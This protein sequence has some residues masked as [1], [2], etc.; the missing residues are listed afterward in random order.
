M[1][2]HC[3]FR[4]FVDVANHNLQAL[5]QV[6]S[7][8]L[9]Q[10]FLIAHERRH[11]VTAVDCKSEDTSPA[12]A[13]GAEQKEPHGYTSSYT[14]SSA[15]ADEANQGAEHAMHRVSCGF[16][17][18]ATFSG[19]ARSTTVLQVEHRRIGAAQLT[20]SAR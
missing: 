10:F 2:D 17:R 3:L 19:G 7:Q 6:A 12:I 13:G 16:S 5:R 14:S 9:C 1:A 11:L 15:H 20:W 18:L 4:R 8:Y